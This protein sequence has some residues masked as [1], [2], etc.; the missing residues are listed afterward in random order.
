M[1][2]AG[3][4]DEFTMTYIIDILFY[5]CASS[6]DIVWIKSSTQ[7]YLDSMSWLPSWLSD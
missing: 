5:G 2:R 3:G 6:N 1:G 7:I 4:I